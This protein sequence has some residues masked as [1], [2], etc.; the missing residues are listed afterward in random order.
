LRG[1]SDEDVERERVEGRGPVRDEHRVVM[2]VVG[3]LRLSRW[4]K[5]WGVWLKEA[6]EGGRQGD[7]RITFVYGL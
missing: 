3:V 5:P 4:T 1:W 7:E 2:F 6:V